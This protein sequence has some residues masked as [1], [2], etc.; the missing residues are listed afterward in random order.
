MHAQPRYRYR[1][2]P[3]SWANPDPAHGGQLAAIT[4]GSISLTPTDRQLFLM[5]ARRHS[6]DTQELIQMVGAAATY[7]LDSGRGE[8]PEFVFTE[9]AILGLDYLTLRN[10]PDPRANVTLATARVWWMRDSAAAE[11]LLEAH[12]SKAT[13]ISVVANT[14]AWTRFWASREPDPAWRA[15][16]IAKVVELDALEPQQRRVPVPAN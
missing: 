16:Y 4:P 7:D 1:D 3:R 14:Y 8:G 6:L 12:P 15:R 5:V 13:A 9:P 2:A 10:V 11:W